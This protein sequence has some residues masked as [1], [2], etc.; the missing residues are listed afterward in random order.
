MQAVLTIA[1]VYSIRSGGV[2]PVQPAG[3]RDARI[4]TSDLG[5]AVDACL[6]LSAWTCGLARRSIMS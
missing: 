3:G 1:V 5:C 6:F 2:L 4:E